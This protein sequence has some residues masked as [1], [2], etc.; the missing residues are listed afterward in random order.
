MKTISTLTCS[1]EDK[2]LIVDGVLSIEERQILRALREGEPH[3]HVVE[4]K[5]L[6]QLVEEKLKQEVLRSSDEESETLFVFVGEGGKRIKKFS[7]IHWRYRTTGVFAKRLWEVGRDPIHLVG[8]IYN[9]HTHQIIYLKVE[10]IIVLDDVISSGETLK[11]I[12]QRSAWKFPR[13]RW[14]AAALVGRGWKVGGYKEIFVSLIVTNGKVPSKK[15]PINTLKALVENREMARSYAF[16]N[17]ENPDR[18]LEFLEEIRWERRI[19]F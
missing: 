1:D 9:S 11:K 12:F 4:A 17:L 3:L 8:Q 19:I 10:V 7:T 14:Y 6:W 2:V 13:A 15:V 18:F 5:V 16:R